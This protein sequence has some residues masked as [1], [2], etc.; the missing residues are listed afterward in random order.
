MVQDVQVVGFLTVDEQRAAAR[1]SPASSVRIR[2][3]PPPPPISQRPLKLQWVPKT[4][5]DDPAHAFAMRSDG[6][7][8]QPSLGSERPSPTP[9]VSSFS[10]FYLALFLSPISYDLQ[11]T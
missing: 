9:Q 6:E 2:F 1:V 7:A 11:H 10:S 3:T 8:K 5:D 4:L